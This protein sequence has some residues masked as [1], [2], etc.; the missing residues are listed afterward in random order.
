MF[1]NTCLLK[2]QTCEP[3][4]R[5]EASESRFVLGGECLEDVLAGFGGKIS[6]GVE[7]G[8]LHEGEEFLRCGGSRAFLGGT[9]GFGGR[10]GET[11]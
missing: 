10:E 4:P 5:N 9:G 2:R 6:L 1:V 7:R 3:F 8:V 11:R